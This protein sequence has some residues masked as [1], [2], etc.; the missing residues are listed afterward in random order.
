M[1]ARIAGNTIPAGR[2]EA[3]PG[4]SAPALLAEVASA[5]GLSREAATLYLQVLALAEPT[6]KNVL[7]WNQW[8][9]PVYKQA[10][11]ELVAAGRVVEGK[12]ERAGRE[13]FLSGAWDKGLGKSLPME[14]WKKPLY[15]ADEGALPRTLPLVP[16]PEIFAA[17]YARVRSGD[18]PKLEE[19]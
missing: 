11:A 12:R 4:V 5:T 10:A 8:K 18:V 3:D 7:A 15:A 16:L 2:H 19:V 14:R 13:I 17:A 9:P 6:Q 1:M